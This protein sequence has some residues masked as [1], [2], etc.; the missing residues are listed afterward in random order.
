MLHLNWVAFNYH[1]YDGY[2]R[3]SLH[4]IRALNR[5]G[6]EVH[7]LLTDQVRL[8]GWMQRMAGL[9]YSNLTITCTPPFMLCPLP[10][11]QWNLTMTEGTQLPVGWPPHI[12]RCVERV[13]VPC[14]HNRRAFVSSGVKVPVDVSPGGTCPWEFPVIRRDYRNNGHRPYTFLAL[15]DRGARK[16]WV[17][18]W[19]AFYQ[20]FG[21]PE[22]TQDARLLIKTRP[23]TNDLIDRIIPVTRDP[24][25]RFWNDDAENMADVYMQA[26][27]FAIPS[28]SEGWGMPH[29]EAA[30]MGL[31]VL[32]TR[33]SGLEDG[34]DHWAIPIESYQMER[35]DNEFL[36]LKGEWAR[37]DTDELAEKMRGC[38]DHRQAAARRGQQAAQWLRQHQ[39]WDHAARRL[40][41]LIEEAA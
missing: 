27:C 10:G 14:E 6:V 13:I 33:Y 21:P 17:E 23:N 7:P 36:H 8:P 22:K 3:Y 34:I 37:V 1:K 18:V 26:D 40:L 24:R 5:L 38:Y 20:A 41:A 9:D 12:N 2:G 15:A 25:V 4:L 11:K 31:P 35:I 32:A 39:T 16:G 19:S 30:M 29:R 28:R